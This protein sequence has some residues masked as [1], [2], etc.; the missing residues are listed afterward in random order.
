MDNL[1]S[2][3]ALIT[4]ALRLRGCEAHLVM[5]DG[6]LSGCIL[7]E[8]PDGVAIADWPQRCRSCAGGY[9]RAVES[10][11]LPY[12]GIGDYVSPDAAE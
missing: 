10:F 11:D 7:R 5:C 6:V 9:R 3:T 8:L 12:S 2:V 4:T 1:L